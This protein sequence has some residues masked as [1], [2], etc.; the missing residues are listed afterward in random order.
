MAT[1][2]VVATVEADNVPPRVRL[3]VTDTGTPAIT[4]VNVTR[5]DPDGRTVPVRT[6]DGNPLVLTTS[7][8][9]RVGLVYDYEMPHGETVTY[10]IEG[11]SIAV[12]VTVPDGGVWLVHPGVP[13]LSMPIDFRIG[14]FDET[15]NDVVRG[16][17]RPMGRTRPIVMVGGPR[18]DD[19]SQ[20][21]VATETSSDSAALKALLADGQVLRLMVPPSI[22]LDI[23]T[24]Y[25][26]PGAL[27]VRR[28]SSIG[29]DPK[30]DFQIPYTVVDRP[31]GGSQAQRTYVDLLEYPTYASLLAAYPTYL[32]VLSG[33]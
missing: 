2:T 8:S 25:I 26:S 10:G 28:V 14:S 24:A 27:T 12:P 31:A 1:V 23:P 11:S 7:G 5:L 4:A 29:T 17:F 20:F 9:N 21:V 15:V 19:E 13:S 32:S 33:P 6:A 22:G 30:R 3:D 16:V 18:L